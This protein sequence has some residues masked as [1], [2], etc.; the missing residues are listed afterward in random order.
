MKTKP[1]HKS[2]KT[3]WIISII[4]AFLLSIIIVPPLVNLNSLKPNIENVIYNQTG[5]K[6]K[7][8]GNI[9]FSLLGQTTIIAHNISIPNGVIQSF[10]FAVPWHDI[11][12][13]KNATI[14]GD[15]VINGAS[16]LIEKIVPF[17]INTN[18]V[19]NNSKIEFLNK[20]YDVI[21]A[22]LSKN[23][24]DALVRTDQHKYEIK[25]VNNNFVIQNKNNKLNISGELLPNG[26]A[27]ATIDIT[28]QNINK[29]F[30]FE[31]PKINGR[32]PVSANVFWDGGYGFKFS[33]I[34]ANGITGNATLQPDGYK[35]VSL[36][37]D[38]ADYDL[39]FIL[40]NI[41]LLQN[42]TLNLDLNGKIKFL[43]KTFSHLS[44]NII[45][46]DDK[47]QIIKIN[48]DDLSISGGYIDKNGAHNVYVSLPENGIPT[49]CIFNGTSIKWSCK[50]FSYNNDI[51]GEMNV[52]NHT[53]NIK[54]YSK[55]P[56]SNIQDI[57]NSVKFIGHRGVVKFDFENMTGVI[58]IDGK[59]TDVKYSFAKNRS[60]KWA[61]ID[62]PFLPQE[63]LNEP[64]S[65]LWRGNDIIFIPNSKKWNIKTTKDYFYISGDNFKVWFKNLDLQ[66]INDLPYTVSGNY[67]RGN[68][69]DLE[70]NIAG[71][72]FTGSASGKTITLK[73]NVLNLDSFISKNFVDNF[74]ELSFFT[75]LPITLPFEI[76]SDLSLSA[77]TLIYQGQKYDNFV[78]ALK[79]NKQ[80]FSISDFARGNLLATINKSKTNYDIQIQMNKFMWD[81]TLL[82]QKMP[83]NISDTLITAEIE[84]N[85]YG[86]TAND[87]INNISG[88]FDASF[89]G[90]YL[91]GLGISDFY[92]SAQNINILNAEYALSNA[93]ENGITPI[94]KMHI[95]GDYNNGNINTTTPFTLSMKHADATGTI[96]IKNN[97][98]FAIMNLILRGTSSS[99]TP[100]EITVLPN[101]KREYSLSEIMM[102]FDIEYMRSFIKLHDKF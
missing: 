19:L 2:R 24:V 27:I 17:D 58:H 12:D 13:L 47:I 29:W 70:I 15:I 39:S 35:I 30:E 53:F 3:W 94:K 78:Y 37:T 88:N 54:V 40:Q 44:V 76:G 92:S 5:I 34:S 85:T 14:S 28:A 51:F 80:T 22:K 97:Q 87:V 89:N 64:G 45:G 1:Q 74:E 43:D 102:N 36:Q 7:I 6:A 96:D 73:T 4:G 20:T 69:S 11:F 75:Q 42:S 93:L 60:L 33:N 26:T 90:G 18:I 61:E 38:S 10:E 56:L 49:T 55:R 63:M 50:E 9:N 95:I 48:A 99:P 21:F 91:Y 72:K 46:A 62:L 8:H 16:L 71:H 57:I 77:K 67:K 82:K 31:K 83:L 101:G 86:K 100:I 79:T 23:Y 81:S 52:D 65:F 59:R 32:F 41:D 98:M 25:S 84:L 68:I 66:S